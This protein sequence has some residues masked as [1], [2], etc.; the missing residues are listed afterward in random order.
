MNRSISE[1][2]LPT[3]SSSSLSSGSNIPSHHSG[4]TTS[5]N[6]TDEGLGHSSILDI[7]Q[8]AGKTLL[9]SFK[10]R[11]DDN[12][13]D[14]E[15]HPKRYNDTG[16]LFVTN[17]Q[18]KLNPVDEEQDYTRDNNTSEQG[19]ISLNISKDPFGWGKWETTEIG[20]GE[21]TTSK[22]GAY[23]TTFLRR[24]KNSRKRRENINNTQLILRGYSEEVSYLRQ[25]YNGEY[26][27]P[28]IIADERENQLRL[29]NED[30]QKT[31]QWLQAVKK[32]EESSIFR[33]SIVDLTDKIKN[34][35]LN[36]THLNKKSTISH[37]DLIFIRERKQSPL[38]RKHKQYL[39]NDEKF[40]KELLKLQSEFKHYRQLIEERRQ[41]Q[42]NV[43][44]Q[45]EEAKRKQQKLVP[46]ISEKKLS[47]VKS[48]LKRND[49]AVLFNKDNIEVTI[50]DFKTLTPRRWLNDTII[51]FFMKYVEWNTEQTV[52]FNSFFYSSLSQRG[53]QGVRRWMKR[54]KVDIK[55]LKKIFT[56]INLNQSHWALGVIDIERKRI[57]YVDSMSSGP[58][59]RSLNILND[60]KG[61]V[62]EESKHTMGEDFELIHGNCPQQPNGFDCGIYV[63]MNA[64]YLSKDSELTFN[65][66]DAVHMRSYIADLILSG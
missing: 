50:R 6:D 38:E 5:G 17:K 20:K 37:D 25:I 51:E 59:A 10:S 54:K 18:R 46:R 47:L 63:C 35:L 14:D 7:M 3:S 44:K 29:I 64:L 41:I 8:S 1:N 57:L 60:L 27:I 55:D 45:R 12:D 58:N 30:K 31:K 4:D 28:K 19:N 24:N 16:Y 26:Q 22:E 62:I 61:Y 21:V 52:A 2:H 49:N 11:N 32:D 33:R 40:N 66:E 42:D 34:I 56:P 53:Y 48:T 23:G 15:H 36:Q 65:S 9:H 13:N 43:R 39:E